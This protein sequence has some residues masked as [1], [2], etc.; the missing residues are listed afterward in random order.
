[1]K[2]LK[3]ILSLLTIVALTT[4]FLNSCGGPTYIEQ[5]EIT[6]EIT[7][8]YNTNLSATMKINFA[9]RSDLDFQRLQNAYYCEER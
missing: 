9:Q 2:T 3:P 1:M 5:G 6:Y 7:Y 8:P 4:V